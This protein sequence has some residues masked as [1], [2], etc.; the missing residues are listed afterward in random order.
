MRPDV[1][2]LEAFYASPMGR[3]A[4]RLIG[5]RL[6]VLLGNLKGLRVL[7]IGYGP[8][9]LA[10]CDDRAER[11]IAVMPER[12]GALAWPSGGPSRSV[13]AGDMALPFAD[14][15]FDRVVIVH[16]LEFLDHARGALR[17]VW[18]VLSPGGRVIIVAPNR[19]GPWSHL[20]AT[21]FGNGRPFSRRQLDAIL[22]DCLLAPRRWDTALHLPPFALF[23]RLMPAL[24]APGS[25]LWPAFAGVHVVAAEKIVYAARPLCDKPRPAS[26]GRPKLAGPLATR[27]SAWRGG[28]SPARRAS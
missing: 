4:A 6:H 26:L 7:A 25:A 1:Q 22:G 14:A 15:L 3:M 5:A 2:A 8:P 16:G 19:T 28:K 21:P 24:E 17:E 13:L 11:S 20:E 18:R 23:R 12:Q 27:F 9:Y 10:A